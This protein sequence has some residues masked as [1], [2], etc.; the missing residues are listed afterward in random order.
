MRG[1]DVMKSLLGLQ[2]VRDRKKI[3]EFL[4]KNAKKGDIFVDPAKTA[5]CAASIC[6]CE[7][8]IGN[9]GTGSLMARSY[10]KYGQDVHEDDVEVGDIIIFDFVNN[11]INGHVAYFD[12]WDDENNTIHVLG[13][14]QQNMVCYSN[15]I[16]DYVVG[17]RRYVK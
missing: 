14:N 6:G 2:E 7:R 16:Q 1:I 13:G 9:P 5:W 3:M 17:I 12:S 4:N 10:L 11:G 8:E 15:Y